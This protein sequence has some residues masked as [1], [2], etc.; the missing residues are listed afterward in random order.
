MASLTGWIAAALILVAASIPLTPRARTGK[1]AAPQSPTIRGH[2]LVALATS[3]AAFVHTLVVLPELGSPA[4][5]GAG[6]IAFV[7]GA[8]AFFVLVAHAGFGMRLRDPKLK[9]RARVRRRHVTTAILL[10]LAV[11]VHVV[12]LLRAAAAS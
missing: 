8:G 3:F 4:A 7:A 2:V 6:A 10:S 5:V 11:A 1:R 12:L 9:D